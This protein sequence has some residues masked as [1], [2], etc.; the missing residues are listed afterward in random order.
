MITP[1]RLHSDLSRLGRETAMFLATVASLSDDEMAAP[2]LCEGWSRADVIAH[3]AANA[4]A[5]VQLIEWAATGE[6]RPL[7]ASPEA[8]A[9]GIAVLAAL[10][11]EELLAVLRSSADCF[12]EEAQRLSGPLAAPEVALGGN[13]L[14][15]ATIVALS[16]R[17]NAERRSLLRVSDDQ[18]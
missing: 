4:R 15:A 17:A 12:A 18:A 7:Y 16:P 9:D 11:R 6:E 2:S 8:R 13:P 3:V 10:P 1:A 14:P 5:L